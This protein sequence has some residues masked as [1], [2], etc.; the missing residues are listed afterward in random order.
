M[1]FFS[2]LKIR[3]KIL[4]CFAVIVIIALIQGIF[5]TMHMKDISKSMKTANILTTE[6]IIPA[7]DLKSQFRQL[8]IYAIRITSGQPKL[9]EEY[10]I[11]I[12]TQLKETGETIAR[13]QKAAGTGQTAENI[14]AIKKDYEKYADIFKQLYTILRDESKPFEQ[15]TEEA[16]AITKVEMKEIGN[17]A[18][19]NILEILKRGDKTLEKNN[20]EAEAKTSPAPMIAIAVIITILSL[21]FA[22]LLSKSLGSRTDRLVVAAEKVSDGDLTVEVSS[23]SRDEVGRLTTSINSM[24]NSLRDII[25]AMTGHSATISNSVSDLEKTSRQIS[26]STAQIL[27]QTI[28]VSAASEE[29]AATSKEIATNCNAA[30]VAS[31]ETKTTTQNS[32]DS[33]RATVAKI[34]DHSKKTEEDAGI[35]A[36]LGEETKQIDTII[37]TIQDIANQTNLLAL[38]AAIEAA[39][40][41]EHGRGFAVVSDEVRALAN[42]TAQST[43]EIN[44][45]IKAVQDEVDVASVSFRDTVQQ[46]EEIAAETENIE[47]TLDLIVNK[48]N[49]VNNQINQIAVA[50]EEQ[51]STSMDM[52][53]NLQKIALLTKDVSSNADSTLH[54]TEAMAQLSEEMTAD[55]M[56]FKL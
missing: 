37:A 1:Q 14:G 49:D 35:I 2:D 34:R 26:E 18:D 21:I 22:Q 16:F 41:G 10:E 36:K 19:K 31:E 45:M 25:K 28:A 23:K 38:N 54:A 52:S 33:V 15:R 56:K 42:R 6:L 7:T 13:I 39:R 12:S 43:Q 5:S 27:N 29:M 8:R 20:Q 55:S 53:S 48:V 3:N 4:L 11:K 9:V 17:D 40:A 50:T 46:M 24:I 51:T 32:I 47:N 30:A 44:K